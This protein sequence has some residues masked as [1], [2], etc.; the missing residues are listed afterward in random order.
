MATPLQILLDQFREQTLA[1]RDQGTS[2]EKLMIQY[3]STEAFYRSFYDE[4]LPRG[5]GYTLRCTSRYHQK[6]GY[7]H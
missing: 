1:V 3:F 4:V 5:L 7:W 2:F 6:D